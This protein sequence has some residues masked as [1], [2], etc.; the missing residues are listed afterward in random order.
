MVAGWVAMPFFHSTAQAQGTARG[1]IS[2][3]V[4]D[5]DTSEPLGFATILIIET[6]RGVLA[7]ENGRFIMG[8]L[9]VGTYTL[10]ASRIGYEP[11][12][13]IATV[14]PG[15]TTFAEFRMTPTVYRSRMIEIVGQRESNGS[16]VDVDRVIGGRALRQQLSRTLAETLTNEPGMSQS[17]MGPAPARPVLRG[18]AGD[19][20]L[21]LE[22]GR[23]TGDLSSSS[24]DHA[25]AI[26]PLNADRIEIIR[27]PA[28]L[29]Y[30]SNT[31]AGV[32]NVVRGQIPTTLIHHYHGTVSLQGE[33]VNSG[34]SAGAN[35]Y[36][37]T[38]NWA[39]KADAS[40]RT[41]GNIQTPE[42]E[43]KNTGMQTVHAALGTSY[44]RDWGLIGLSTNVLDSRYG[45]PGDFVGAHPKGVKINMQRFQADVRA[46]LTPKTG[47]FRQIEHHVTYSYYFHEELEYS[48]QRQRHDLVG[49][50]FIYQSV[51]MHSLWNH[52]EAA[53]FRRGQLGYSGGWARLTVGGYSF[54]PPTNETTIALYGFE[55]VHVGDWTIQASA[56][57]DVQ[58]VI[59]DEERNA[60][61]GRIRTRTFAEPS[62][63]IRM[64]RTIGSGF[65]IGVNGMRTI[66][67]PSVKELFSE[68]PHLPA[69]SYEVGNPDLQA[70]RGWGGEVFVRSA[71]D[72]YGIQF[73]AYANRIQ[74]YLYPRNTGEFAVQRPLPI[75]QYTGDDVIMIGMEALTEWR[76]TQDLH[77]SG[78]VSW[79]KGSIIDT[80]RPIPFVPPLSGKVNLDYS[81]KRLTLGAGLRAASKQD[82]LGEF[83][84]PTDGYVVADLSAQAHLTAGRALHTI[85]LK[86]ENVTDRAYR[87]HLS[88]VKAIMPEPGRTV[89][90]LYRVYF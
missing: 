33:T 40:G 36:G 63:A 50:D 32:I 87:M 71:S 58:S 5:A 9:V 17:T 77:I 51:R 38:G 72:R 70:E 25:L 2:G 65:E 14:S 15:D 73:S 55:D 43:L 39:Y 24:P 23:S 29:M 41:A 48:P 59:P 28:A 30:S 34:L 82:R 26:D 60:R 4:R 86:A 76:L 10:R 18:L 89:S 12:I 8:N 88:R 16:D 44:I 13:V 35:V 47:L 79:V 85:S 64:T 46:D 81:V 56:R 90:V 27:G 31:L 45:I 7:H 53:I 52:D 21:I 37:S 80:G 54:T 11:I 22:D 57:F 74:N 62:A 19:R 68:G 61:I 66:R 1:A 6:N 83:E 84:E 67:I 49:S 69:Y 42:G 20:L 3:Q 78:T 75:Y